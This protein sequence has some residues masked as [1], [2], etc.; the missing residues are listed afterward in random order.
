M[1]EV[2][3]EAV[4]VADVEAIAVAL[5]VALADAEGLAIILL[6]IRPSSAI[7]SSFIC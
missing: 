7:W 1:A 3:A 4:A 2:V 5:G 6:S